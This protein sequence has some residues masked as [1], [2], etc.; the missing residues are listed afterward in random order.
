MPS[1]SA[2]AAHTAH[3]A[4]TEA[5]TAQF[6]PNDMQSK[7][8]GYFKRTVFAAC[9]LGIAGGLAQAFR[10]YTP[11]VYHPANRQLQNRNET[12]ATIPEPQ[13]KPATNTTALIPTPEPTL[14]PCPEGQYRNDQNHKNKQ[15]RNLKIALGAIGGTTLAGLAVNVKWG[16]E[17]HQ[18]KGLASCACTLSAFSSGVFIITS[19]LTILIAKSTPDGLCHYPDKSQTSTGG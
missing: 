2:A 15:M 12:A 7:K 11:Q 14:E 16:H 9:A 6:K 1:I 8:G 18:L 13:N 10:A 5:Q 3:F 17:E 19:I 4:D